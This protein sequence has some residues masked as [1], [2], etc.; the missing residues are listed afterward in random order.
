MSREPCDFDR[1]PDDSRNLP[2]ALV[3]PSRRGFLKL[4]ASGVAA[5]TA[6]TMIA[7]LS[8]AAVQEPIVDAEQ[9]RKGE[10]RI[11]L[12]VNGHLHEL[13]VPVNAILLDTLRDRLGLFGT[14]KGCD[15]GQCGACTLVVNG[16]S[17]NSCLSISVQHDGDQITTIEG[18][19]QEGKLHAIQ[20]AFWEHD[21]Y[22]CG[23]CTPGQIMSAYAL[24]QDPS[25]GTDDDSVR[26]AMSGNI[27][28][29]GAYKNI[30]SAIQ[31][32]RTKMEA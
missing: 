22:Q 24:L 20:E 2:S 19:A 13:N 23:Y 21:A 12:Q 18:L 9:P 28:R 27:C 6:S 1:N 17:I 30:L 26:E 7:D 25:I 29:C 5:I 16:Q 4:G 14:K 15:Q 11:T 8:Q 10:K 32:A 3:A 31:S